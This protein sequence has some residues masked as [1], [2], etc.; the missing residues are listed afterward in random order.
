MKPRNIPATNRKNTSETSSHSHLSYTIDDIIQIL[1]L[2]H[3][4]IT[5]RILT[6]FMLEDSA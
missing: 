1:E 3:Y 2:I 4:V 6:L 5:C